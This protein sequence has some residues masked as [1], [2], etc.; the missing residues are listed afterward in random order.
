M[1]HLLW[2]EVHS[3]DIKKG[4]CENRGTVSI[5]RVKHVRD[6]GAGEKK[7]LFFDSI[8]FWWLLTFLGSDYLTFSF[9]P[10]HCFLFFM[11][12]YPC[13]C[14]IRTHVIIT[15]MT[16]LESQDKLFLI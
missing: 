9:C 1:R 7:N 2:P 4:V 14:L 16:D 6:D 3:E 13:F 15:L 12:S 10:S 11:F 8:G 5:S